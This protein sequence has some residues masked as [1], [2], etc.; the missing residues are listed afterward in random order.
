[1]AFFNALGRAEADDKRFAVAAALATPAAAV[2][3]SI[4]VE[5]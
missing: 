3:F 5:P 4:E 1:M 2:M